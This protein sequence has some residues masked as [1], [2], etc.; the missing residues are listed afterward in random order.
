MERYFSA[1]EWALIQTIAEGLE[2]VQ[3]WTLA[4]A[5]RIRFILSFS[6]ATGL[7]VS[8]LVNATLGQIEV[9]GRGDR[10]LHVIGKGEKKAKVAL[11][12]LARACWIST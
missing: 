5:Q 8:E 12:S 10:W 4:A 1:G 7:R 6:F 11:P 9:D 3:G 2:W